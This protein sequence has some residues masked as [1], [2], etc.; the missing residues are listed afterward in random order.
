MVEELDPITEAVSG[1]IE[2][3][4]GLAPGLLESTYVPALACELTQRGLKVDRQRPLPAANKG[5]EVDIGCRVD[6]LAEDQVMVERLKPAHEAQPLS[7]LCL[8]SPRVLLLDFNA[9][10]LNDGIKRLAW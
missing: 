6:L 9:E 3:H 4:R 7:Y 8:S 2:V 10:V 1:A 5:L